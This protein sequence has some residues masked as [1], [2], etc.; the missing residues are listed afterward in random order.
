ML[1]SKITLS[2][3]NRIAFICVSLMVI[4]NIFLS[5][6][7][8]ELVKIN[9]YNSIDKFLEG[10]IN[11]VSEKYKIQSHTVYPSTIIEWQEKEHRSIGRHAVFI[12]FLNAQKTI[13]EK[14]PNLK[15]E[16]LSLKDYENYVYYNSRVHDFTIR[17]IHIPIVT[18]NNI[19]GYIIV[20]TPIEETLRV[21]AILK[22]SFL[23][24]FPFLIIILFF[25]SRH[26]A[27]SS[28]R[29]IKKII[30]ISN[31]IS[32]KNLSSRIPLS[33]NKDELYVLSFTINNLLDRL[34][35]VIEREKSFISFTSHE[36]KTPLSVIKGTLQVLIRK[37]REVK[38]YE[39]KSLY[40]ISQVDKLNDLIE[41]LLLLTQYETNKVSLSL[42]KVSIN[43]VVTDSLIGF[44][45]Q[46]KE[47]KLKIN[48][49]EINDY[50]VY[51]DNFMFLTIINNLLSNAIKYS[52]NEGTIDICQSSDCGFVY[53]MI[54]N[55]GVSINKQEMNS[56]F[57]PFYR[58]SINVERAISGHGLGLSI[59]REFCLLLN[60]EISIESDERS[61]TVA[62]LK[63]PC[64]RSI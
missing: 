37:P 9:S 62:T 63:I 2:L 52:F 51:T 14:S 24:S 27:A 59:V 48:F 15:E 26:V 32:H 45:I 46:I 64:S 18:N 13:I 61:G 41:D 7:V 47:K 3:K 55:F 6:V 33:E 53:C 4:L 11:L 60:M 28:I 57:N 56:V 39:Q 42:E 31:K 20:A 23:I 54:R 16:S 5:L 34:E 29:P 40:C 49:E 25:I 58:S 12:Q 50:S 44:D 36:F 8:Y 38:E 35:K 30:D 17:Q 1:Y 22:Y 21:L 19:S 10:E 43:K